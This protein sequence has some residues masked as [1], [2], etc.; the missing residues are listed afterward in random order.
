MLG[1]TWAWAA[2]QLEGSDWAAQMVVLLRFTSL[3]LEGSVV[4]FDL[5]GK[6]VCLC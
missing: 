2:N 1:D 4:Y 3:P 5:R 6:W